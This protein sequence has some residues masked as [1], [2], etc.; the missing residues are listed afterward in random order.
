MSLRLGT[1]SS[2]SDLRPAVLTK[3][4]SPKPAIAKDTVVTQDAKDGR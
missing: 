4:H 2:S 3:G 1:A